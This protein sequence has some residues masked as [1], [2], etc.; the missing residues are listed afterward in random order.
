[1]AKVNA[2]NLVRIKTSSWAV[3]QGTFAGIIGLAVA[4][5]YSLGN[6]IQAADATD[7]VLQGLAFGLATGVISI[8]VLPLIYFAIGW[9]VGLIQAF[10]FNVVLGAAGGITLSLEDE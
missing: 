1:M 2:K 3:F 10:I 8:I 4:I 6:T 7:S 5:L 9:V